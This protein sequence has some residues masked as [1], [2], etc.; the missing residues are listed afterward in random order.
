MKD[1]YF[2]KKETCYYAWNIRVSHLCFLW[3]LTILFSHMKIYIQ[4][5]INIQSNISFFNWFLI[6]WWSCGPVII[7]YLAQLEA[8]HDFFYPMFTTKW[9][10]KLWKG[11]PCELVHASFQTIKIL[12]VWIH[13]F[14]LS[15]YDFL[16]LISIA[17]NNLEIYRSLLNLQ[18]NTDN[19]IYEHNHKTLKRTS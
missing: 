6:F 5:C 11:Y 8:A 4:N 2:K 17:I 9:N 12:I 3:F 18:F 14:V 19:Q 10:I 7:S 1:H 16:L 15:L 13:L